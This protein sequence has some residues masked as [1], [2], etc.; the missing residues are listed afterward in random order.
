MSFLNTI[1]KNDI[2]K[3]QTPFY[4]YS[5]EEIKKNIN[6]YKRSFDKINVSFCYALKANSN[7]EILKII[8]NQNFRADVVSAGEIIAAKKAGFENKKIIFSGVGKTDYELEMAVKENIFLINVESFSEL[9]KLSILSDKFNKRINFSIRIN[10]DVSVNTHKYVIT[11]KSG[12]KFGVD[13]NLAREMYIFARKN[14]N[15]FP[16]A[17]HFHLGSQIFDSKPYKIAL[18]KI[19]KFLE[20]MKKEG[21]VISNIDIGGGWGIKEGS[22]L[23]APLDIANLLKSYGDRFNFILEP[24]RSIIASAGC[25]VVK[26]LYLKK[27]GSKKIVIVDGGMSDFIRPSFYGVKH[28]ALNISKSEKSKM[29]KVDIYG[30]IC[31]SGDFLAKDIYIAEP[32]EGDILLFLSAGAYGYSMSSNY[33]LRPKPAEY[34]IEKSK[35][36]MIRERQN[37]DKFI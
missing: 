16:Y 30:P 33:N 19:V 9:K 8:K 26:I 36:R 1:K 34:L 24:G 3:I 15:L 2:K 17:V 6:I 29:C 18:I 27:S 12:S 5:E 10:P 4:L 21:I 28:P 7:I 11:G 22:E 35:I 31:E 23:K 20:D 14:K 37:Y 32:E 25:F 13:M